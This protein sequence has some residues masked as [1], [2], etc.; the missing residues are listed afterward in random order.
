MH[1][2]TPYSYSLACL[3]Y[4][5]S[6]IH[7]QNSLHCPIMFLGPC[8]HEKVLEI[9]ATSLM[10]LKWHAILRTLEGNKLSPVIYFKISL[11]I[12]RRSKLGPV[13]SVQ[14]TVCS[15]YVI[16]LLFTTCSYP[17]LPSQ[18][19]YTSRSHSSLRR[20]DQRACFKI[21]LMHPPLHRAK[22]NSQP[23]PC[24]EREIK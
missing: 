1:I 5:C 15:V 16:S 11:H 24:V 9:Y 19:D 10:C 14:K 8:C 17:L 12:S 23:K 7:T 18:R 6:A 4:S 3:L 20:R 22:C 21:T 2:Q 13:F